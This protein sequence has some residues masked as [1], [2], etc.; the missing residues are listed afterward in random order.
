MRILFFISAMIA[1][2]LTSEASQAQERDEDECLRLQPSI[3]SPVEMAACTSDLT[4]S[5][6]TV[7]KAV[8]ELRSRVPAESRRLL[9]EA[10]RRWT[11]HRNAQ[12]RCEAGGAVG[13][14]MNSS[15]IVGCVADMN[16][17]RANYLRDELK[18]W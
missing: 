12:C 9:D 10:Q 15:D 3:T 4:G 5:E 1:F 11:K 16:R 14:T 2:A 13:S 7:D 17:E 8:A 6:Q 18:R